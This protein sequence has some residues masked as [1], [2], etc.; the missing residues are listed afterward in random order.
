MTHVD[1]TS[2]GH[3]METNMD[4]WTNAWTSGGYCSW[5]GH[6]RPPRRPF[7][8]MLVLGCCRDSQDELHSA[9]EHAMTM[10]ELHCGAVGTR[11][12][13]R[14]ACCTA[15]PR[16]HLSPTSP[17][18]PDSDLPLHPSRLSSD[19]APPRQRPAM[20]LLPPAAMPLP[21]LPQC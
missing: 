17:R 2:H 13:P 3:L 4:P 11:A 12:H 8:P 20:S 5:T 18:D 7:A 14:A 19:A 10:E 9:V 21:S 1:K 15:S 16:A 6:V